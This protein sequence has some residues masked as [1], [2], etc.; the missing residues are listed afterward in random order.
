MAIV[1]ITA[2][3]GRL[4][5]FDDVLQKFVMNPDGDA[6][7]LALTGWDNTPLT[8]AEISA[9]HNGTTIFIGRDDYAGDPQKFPI[10]ILAQNGIIT[11][12]T[13]VKVR[14]DRDPTITYTELTLSK[15]DMTDNGDGTFYI[16]VPYV[17]DNGYVYQN[18][19]ETIRWYFPEDTFGD[20][21]QSISFT[22]TDINRSH[23]ENY[24]IDYREFSIQDIPLITEKINVGVSVWN[25]L[26]ED[27]G[28]SKIG[29]FTASYIGTT[30]KA[31]NTIDNYFN[32]LP[33]LLRFTGGTPPKIGYARRIDNTSSGIHFNNTENELPSDS[34]WTISVSRKADGGGTGWIWGKSYSTDT[35]G[36]LGILSV[37]SDT[38]I[39][40]W[41]TEIDIPDSINAGNNVYSFA[42]D[43]I[44]QTV[45]VWHDGA[46]IS[47]HDV[48]GITK[49]TNTAP[50]TCAGI[51]TNDTLSSFTQ[52]EEADFKDFRLCNYAFDN[53]DA[54][55]EWANYKKTV[56][57]MQFG[58][59]VTNREDVSYYE[60]TGASENLEFVFYTDG[61][62]SSTFYRSCFDDFVIPF[63]VNGG[64]IPDSQ[65]R[66]ATPTISTNLKKYKFDGATFA[67]I[68]YNGIH[69]GYVYGENGKSL[70]AYGEYKYWCEH[71][72]SKC[73]E[74][75]VSPL[76]ITPQPTDVGYSVTP[77]G[78]KYEDVARG[79]S[80]YLLSAVQ[81]FPNV[82]D[83]NEPLRVSDIDNAIQA[84]FT[85]DSLHLNALGYSVKQPLVYNAMK[86]SITTR[87]PCLG[88][89]DPLNNEDIDKIL[90]DTIDVDWKYQSGNE[91]EENTGSEL[92]TAGINTITRSKT[93]NYGFEGSDSINVNYSSTYISDLT[94]SDESQG[95]GSLQKD[96]NSG[97]IAIKVGGVEYNKGWGGHCN[98]YVEHDLTVGNFVEFSAI[99][100][101]DSSQITDD[102]SYRIYVDSIDVTGPLIASTTVGVPVTVPLDNN[103]T[104]KIEYTTT[105]GLGGSWA[106]IANGRLFE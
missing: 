51:F 22:D 4:Y 29:D 49:T 66:T 23:T 60:E 92:L 27:N 96:L 15:E 47:T 73:E 86:K 72:Q 54:F 40:V 102:I 105:G 56:S 39:R 28:V 79:G 70:P 6:E 45:T 82:L 48:S 78:E 46:F 32:T 18:N 52:S 1:N 42:Y 83:M 50:I 97:G 95:F 68:L 89:T 87:I 74:L 69:N 11:N 71:V 55:A 16:D 76:F 90:G 91:F 98:G 19:S 85:D 58:D 8:V 33:E 9:Q 36:G 84:Q 67:Y 5:Y 75:N 59:S 93:N 38:K 34:S 80:D 37:G 94:P 26:H 44:G 7:L 77:T 25:T 53:D 104:L 81:T 43:H 41:G 17:V 10:M 64:F 100:G 63:E 106:N 99:L 30:E 65:S 103:S 21:P 2:Y 20:T 62:E 35:A 101:P 14:V 24:I 3:T 57:W 13:Q 61:V 12:S 31:V 88:I